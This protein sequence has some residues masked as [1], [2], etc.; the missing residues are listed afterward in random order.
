MKLELF[1]LCDFAQENN[2][3]L[4]IVG[5]FDTIAARAFPC[6]HPSLMVV[7]R[8]RF[9]LWE[10]GTHRFTIEVRDIEGKHMI[11]PL[12][13]SIDVRSVGNATAVSHVLFSLQNFALPA[14]G[15]ASFTLYVDEKEIGTLPLYI[16]KA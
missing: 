3:K 10:F 7:I 13:G 5:T 2:G 9:D 16:K 12:Q 6:F 14:P 4:T 15:L 11:E 1:T 8:L